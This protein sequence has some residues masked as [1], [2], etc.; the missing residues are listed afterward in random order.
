MPW[1]TWLICY[2]R[3][4]ATGTAICL[5]SVLH[6]AP[7]LSYV[8]G[9]TPLEEKLELR[10]VAHLPKAKQLSRQGYVKIPQPAVGCG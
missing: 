5:A 4:L 2:L 7:A 3:Y 10:E 9:S 6:T 1:L 8:Q